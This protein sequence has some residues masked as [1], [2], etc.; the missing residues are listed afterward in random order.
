MLR[1]N[2]SLRLRQISFVNFESNEF[3]HAA[4]FSRDCAVSDTQKG[5]KHG[6]HA[7]S[8]VQLNAP[9]RKLNRKRSR[10]AAVLLGGFESSHTE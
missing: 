6:L 5:V 7:R 10:D 1:P 9:F 2:S 8:A 3:F 4:I